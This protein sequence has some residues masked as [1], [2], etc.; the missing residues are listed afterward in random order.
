MFTASRVVRALGPWRADAVVT[1]HINPGF[2]ELAE[3]EAVFHAAFQSRRSRPVW[4]RPL[5]RLTGD[6]VRRKA[7]IRESVPPEVVELCWWCRR[8]VAEGSGWR[9]CEACHACRAMDD[10]AAI[11]TGTEAATPVADG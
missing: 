3:G 8:P 6:R 9:P 4:V 5:A 2:S 10:A 11:T 1:G 7:L